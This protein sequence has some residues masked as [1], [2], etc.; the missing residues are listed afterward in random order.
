MYSL[1]YSNTSRSRRLD[2]QHM[3][4]DLFLASGLDDLRS[5]SSS[6]KIQCRILVPDAGHS[7]SCCF[8]SLHYE[9]APEHCLVDSVGSRIFRCR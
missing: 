2:I 8:H 4:S 7:Q 5:Q 9:L 1:L 6:E 3:G